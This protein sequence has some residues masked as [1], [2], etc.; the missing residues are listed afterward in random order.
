MPTPVQMQGFPIALSGRDMI[1]IAETGSG[2]TLAF[3]LPALVHIAAQPALQQDHGPIV[4]V[5]APTRELAA[6][7]ERETAKFID[8]TEYRS[9][10]ATGGMDGRILMGK[11]RHG[12][13][14]LVG[15]PGRLMDIV[16][17]RI[18][19]LERVT[20][21]VLDEADRLLDMGFHRQISSI[22]RMV[23]PDRQTLMWSATWPS[24][25][26]QLA[27]SL[28]RNGSQPGCT[29][30]GESRTEE[31]MV[32]FDVFFFRLARRDSECVGRNTYHAT[33]PVLISC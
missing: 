9:C 14:V 7:I 30:D 3:M 1:G 15:C 12:S 6:Q 10:C 20:Y 24:E 2:K 21:L 16:N 5:I 13:H 4:L 28:C 32:G 27:R 26:Q 11:L 31:V 8:G 25:V 23:R 33:Q 18:T 22:E 29:G 19:N 17:R